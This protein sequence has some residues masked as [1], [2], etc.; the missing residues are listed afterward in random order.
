MLA[1]AL[2]VHWK[3]LRWPLAALAVMAFALPLLAV[4]PLAA[5]RRDVSESYAQLW[6]LSNEADLW[7][8]LFPLLA[9]AVG[10]VVA[11][12]VWYWDHREG[13]VY[14]LSLP[15][16]RWRYVLLQLGAGAALVAV[17]AAFLWAGALAASVRL[18]LP[19]GLESY[20]GLLGLRFLLAAL[21]AYA[22]VFA[23]AA[24]TVTTTLRTLSVAGILVVLLVAVGPLVID[25]VPGEGVVRTVEWLSRAL[26]EWPGPFEVFGGSWRLVD[27]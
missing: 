15:L 1:A 22:L 16:E 17:V 10:S 7:L 9:A 19:A 4:A 14:A 25:S 20:P 21:L 3:T 12:G 2:R 13:H 11:L 5:V 6:F 27:V 18:D 8:P 24:G 23:L 26:T